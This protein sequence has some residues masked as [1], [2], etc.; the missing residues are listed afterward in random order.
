[1]RVRF[2]AFLAVLA[3][4]A[5]TVPGVA[6]VQTGEI[7]GRVTDNTGAVLPGVTITLTGTTLIQPQVAT[8]SATGTYNFPRLPI[9]TYTVKY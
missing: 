4:V 2:T 9:G 1:M 5:S 8:S 3:L 7:T 6:Q